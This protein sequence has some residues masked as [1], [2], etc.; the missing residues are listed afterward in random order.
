VAAITDVDLLVATS[1]YLASHFFLYVLI[2]R[3]TRLFQREAAIFAYHFVS[4]AALVLVLCIVAAILRP[5]ALAAVALH[6]IYSLSFLELWALADASYSIQI[7]EYIQGHQATDAP[8]RL[9]DIAGLQTIGTSKRRLRTASLMRLGLI[10]QRSGCLE[11]TSPG[12]WVA[13]VLAAIAWAAN[14]QRND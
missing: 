7:L 1:V 5:S 14:I 11:V 8:V 9:S 13:A 2:L 4:F 10:R 12:A 6:G 3:R